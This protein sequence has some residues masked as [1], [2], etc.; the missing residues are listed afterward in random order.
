MPRKEDVLDRIARLERAVADLQRSTRLP[1]FVSAEDLEEGSYGGAVILNN[2]ETPIDPANAAF[3]A[4]LIAQG[5]WEMPAIEGYWSKANDFQTVT[6]GTF[7]GT[8]TQEF[9]Q[10]IADGY[11]AS[12]IWSTDP[13]TTGELRIANNVFDGNNT[14]AR[15]LGAGTNGQELFQWLHGQTIGVGPFRPQV[16]ARR[17]GGAG[18]V[19][20]FNPDFGHQVGGRWIS[21]TVAG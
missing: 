11:Q 20:V 5:G 14:N 4:L 8:W 17:T 13:G 12:V 9:W 19:Y 21:A 6:S 18:N 3:V 1:Q 15:T 2:R 7:A 10:A 16:Q